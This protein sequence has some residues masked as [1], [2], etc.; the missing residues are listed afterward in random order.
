MHI[1]G[2]ICH[3]WVLYCAGTNDG[4]EM[5]GYGWVIKWNSLAH[6]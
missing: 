5:S 3:N 6:C 2:L 1:A 4:W